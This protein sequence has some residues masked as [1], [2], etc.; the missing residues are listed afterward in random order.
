[1]SPDKRGE[2]VEYFQRCTDASERRACRL[3]CFEICMT[4]GN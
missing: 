2:L 1:M 4:D 3:P